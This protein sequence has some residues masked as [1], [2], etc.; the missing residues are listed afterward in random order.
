VTDLRERS[1]LATGVARFLGTRLTERLVADDTVA[2]LDDLSTGTIENIEPLVKPGKVRLVKG[3]VTDLA[4]LKDAARAT[5]CV[6]HLAAV[7]EVRVWR[8]RCAA[9][10]WTLRVSSM[11]SWPPGIT[12][13]RGLCL[14]RRL[15]CTPPAALRRSRRNL[16]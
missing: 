6:F 8:I 16:P 1:I 2:V 11:C 14:R 12:A 9:T 13:L 3:S 10:L 7:V 15:R 4:L 5:D